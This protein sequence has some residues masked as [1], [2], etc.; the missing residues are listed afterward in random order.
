MIHDTVAGI[1]PVILSHAQDFP[2][3]PRISVSANQPG[4]LAV[5][6]HPTLRDFFHNGKN[7]INQI[8]VQAVLHFISFFLVNFIC[9]VFI[10]C[11]LPNP[12]IA[13]VY[14]CVSSPVTFPQNAS[15]YISIALRHCPLKF[16]VGMNLIMFVSFPALL[17]T[18]SDFIMLY[19]SVATCRAAKL[20]K[21]KAR[22]EAKPREH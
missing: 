11:S 3:Q 21:K 4:N 1:T 10:Q 5:S 16:I 20:K 13:F 7:F 12:I 14:A 9:S 17:Y 18:C 8:R 15:R 22:Q 19:R 6:R 2:D